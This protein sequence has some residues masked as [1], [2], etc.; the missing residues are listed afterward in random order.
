M[1]Q[2]ISKT[3]DF[4]VHLNSLAYHGRQGTRNA[5]MDFRKADMVSSPR[6]QSP[7]VESNAP[8]YSRHVMQK[9]LKLLLHKLQVLVDS[10][11]LTT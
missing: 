9:L 8:V 6:M 3:V 10:S 5:K 11:Q 2:T 1:R 4:N 7:W